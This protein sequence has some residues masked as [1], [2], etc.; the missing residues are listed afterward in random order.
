ME[1]AIRPYLKK[2]M[3]A[4]IHTYVHTY[5]SI[6]DIPQGAFGYETLSDKKY[7][8]VNRSLLI[9]IQDTTEIKH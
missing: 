3:H 8:N 2:H 5:L 6:H 1:Q 4:Y 9:A 7:F